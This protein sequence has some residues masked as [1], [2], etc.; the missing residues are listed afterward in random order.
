M[1]ETEQFF[2]A[3]MLSLNQ[4]GWKLRL[5]PGSDS[6]CWVGSKR[7]DIGVGY[8]GDLRQI[9]LHEIA[10][11]GTARFCNQKHNETFWRHYEDLVAKWLHTGLDIHQIRHQQGTGGGIY[12]VAYSHG[13]SPCL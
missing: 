10:H 2:K 1:H 5:K 8:A 12:A 11:I 13:V 4:H 7:I 3:V 9:I 6:Y